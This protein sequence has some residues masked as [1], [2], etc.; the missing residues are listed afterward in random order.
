MIKIIVDWCKG[1]GI[2]L[3]RCPRDAFEYSKELNKRGVYPPKLKENNDCHYCKLCELLCPDFA[4]T[5]Q[6]EDEKKPEDSTGKLIIRK[7][8]E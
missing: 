2:C 5:V 1:C 6:D 7:D 4:I 8:D 3:E